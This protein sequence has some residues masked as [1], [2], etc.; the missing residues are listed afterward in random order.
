MQH[1]VNSLFLQPKRN[2]SQLE[3]LHYTHMSDY[4][5]FPCWN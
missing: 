4:T 3:T 1:I 2:T 5:M